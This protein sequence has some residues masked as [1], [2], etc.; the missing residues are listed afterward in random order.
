MPLHTHSQFRLSCSGH[1][2]L[3]IQSLMQDASC[4][5]RKVATFGP[6]VPA[7][8]SVQPFL[9]GFQAV[10]A[11]ALQVGS[12]SLFQYHGSIPWASFVFLVAGHQA[13]LSALFCPVPSAGLF[14]QASLGSRFLSLDYLFSFC[15]IGLQCILPLRLRPLRAATA[16]TL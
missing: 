13:F 15:S 10:F 12:N 16:E 2:Y 8:V 9:L 3:T 7:R 14:P 4:A 11:L 6:F 1:R 5:S